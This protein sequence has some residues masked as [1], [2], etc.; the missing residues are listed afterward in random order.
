MV[1]TEA[2]GG[3]KAKHTHTHTNTTFHK[4]EGK[5]ASHIR[6]GMS[7]VC[8]QLRQCSDVHR[9]LTVVFVYYTDGTNSDI[10]C[11]IFKFAPEEELVR[12][13]VAGCNNLYGQ[14]GYKCR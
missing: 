9:P 12:G 7:A 10:L 4:L 3:P 8:M 11:L 6:L 14:M 1:N 13:H 5:N 2:I